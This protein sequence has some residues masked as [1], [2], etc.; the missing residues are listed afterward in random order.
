MIVAPILL[1]LTGGVGLDFFLDEENNSN[2]DD[3]YTEIWGCTAPDADN[4]MPDA[5]DDDGSCWWD[6]NNGGGG[7]PPDCFERLA[8]G[9][10]ANQRLG[11]SRLRI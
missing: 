5:T 11:R 6:D 7:G 4:Y 9:Q 8:L 1:L 3:Y 10:C 2:S